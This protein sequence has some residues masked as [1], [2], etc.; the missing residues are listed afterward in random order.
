MYLTPQYA[1]KAPPFPHCTTH[2]TRNIVIDT[3]GLRL[4]QNEPLGSIPFSPGFVSVSFGGF[5]QTHST[6]WHFPYSVIRT[7]GI[8]LVTLGPSEP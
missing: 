5:L 8:T 2:C 6:V 7:S 3:F 1:C 4:E